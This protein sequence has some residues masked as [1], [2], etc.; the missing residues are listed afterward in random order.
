MAAPSVTRIALLCITLAG[1]ATAGPAPAR[2]AG[3]APADVV[4]VPLHLPDPIQPGRRAESALEDLAGALLASSSLNSAD[5]PDALGQSVPAIQARYRQVVAGNCLILTYASP[6]TIETMG[7]DVSVHEIV[8]G[9]ARPDQADALFTI[10]AAGRVVAHE[11]YSGAIAVELRR[12][13]DS[14][15]GTP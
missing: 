8:I 13:A 10:D 1:V 12:A 5:E 4:M 6:V 11:K 2:A 9:L 3:P 15:L 14:V 7:G